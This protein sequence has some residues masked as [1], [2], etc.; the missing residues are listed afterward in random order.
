MYLQSFAFV[1]LPLMKAGLAVHVNRRG[2]IDSPEK[3]AAAGHTFRRAH[4]DLLFLHVTTYALSPTVLPVVRRAKVPVIILNLSP[5]AAIDYASFNAMPESAF[6]GR[7]RRLKRS[8]FPDLYSSLATRTAGTGSASGR[9]NSST[10]GPPRAR[11]IT[12][13]SELGTLRPESKSLAYC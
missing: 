1:R 6:C 3:A 11:R 12:A 13:Q 4:V 5:G 7:V 10:P 2:L 8:E 9:G